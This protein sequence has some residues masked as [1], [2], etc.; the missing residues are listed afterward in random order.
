VTCVSAEPV[1]PAPVHDR[2]NVVAAVSTELAAVPLV[3][4][5]P[6]QPPVAVH[7]VAFVED[8]VICVAVPVGTVA[9][10]APMVTVGAAGG[11]GGGGFVPVVTMTVAEALELPPVPVHCRLN[12]ALLVRTLLC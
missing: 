6:L 7:D 4:F 2:P 12:V 8:Q 11:G 9:G 1:P 10:F 3:A 5:D